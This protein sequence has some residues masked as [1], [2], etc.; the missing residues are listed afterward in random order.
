MLAPSSLTSGTRGAGVRTPR[1]QISAGTSHVGRTPALESLGG[2]FIHRDR[3]PRLRARLPPPASRRTARS[4]LI[5]HA[6]KSPD[7]REIR[8][9]L[10]GILITAF[11][12]AL[13]TTLPQTYLYSSAND[14]LMKLNNTR[15]L[16]HYLNASHFHPQR[17]GKA[18]RPPGSPYPR[19]PGTARQYQ[20][21]HPWLRRTHFF[22]GTWQSTSSHSQTSWRWCRVCT[23][24][25]TCA[26]TM[27]VSEQAVPFLHADKAL[28]FHGCSFS[29]FCQDVSRRGKEGWRAALAVIF[30]GQGAAVGTRVTFSWTRGPREAKPGPS[31]LIACSLPGNYCAVTDA[32]EPS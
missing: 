29:G 2:H 21:T 6:V 14:V 23:R 32:L 17:R 16:F 9:H 13:I 24:M 12:S 5:T 25:L 1:D 7:T 28:Y 11:P 26:C 31:P 10:A 4:P 3:Q 18:L 15:A 27:Y 20:T 19:A 30:W 8:L 22:F